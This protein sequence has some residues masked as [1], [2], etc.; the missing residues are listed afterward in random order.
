MIYSASAASERVISSLTGS[1]RPRSSVPPICPASL[2]AT[3]L[4]VPGFPSKQLS[5]PASPHP[6]ILVTPSPFPPPSPSLRTGI[7]VF[8][9]GAASSSVNRPV[10]L[11]LFNPSSLFFSF[12]PRSFTSYALSS[13]HSSLNPSPFRCLIP[14]PLIISLLILSPTL[15]FT[16]STLHLLLFRLLLLGSVDSL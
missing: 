1:S 4:K 9:P 8:H 13:S 16:P 6:S 15:S 12:A 5:S 7:L 3:G 14:S 2:P 10:T 11:S